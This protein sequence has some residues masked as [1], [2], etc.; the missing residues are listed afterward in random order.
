MVWP[1]KIK[2][3][4]DENDKLNLRQHNSYTFIDNKCMLCFTCEP[5]G[6]KQL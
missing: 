1:G 2:R 5:P 3:E 6:I 4:C